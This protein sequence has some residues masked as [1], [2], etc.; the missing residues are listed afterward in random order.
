MT[1]KVID[2]FAGIGGL[3]Q[4]FR[5]EGFS[6]VLAN[7]I[8]PDIAD[9]Y[10]KNH[11]DTIMINEDIQKLD[12]PN[13]FAKYNDIDVIIGGPPCQGFSQK[14]SRK[15]LDDPRNFLFRN[16]YESVKFIKPKYFVIENVPT[17]LTA[18]NGM[19]KNEIYKLFEEIG[20]KLNSDVLSA[21][22]FGVP[23]L[24]KRAILIGRKGQYSLD[25]PKPNSKKITSWEAIS[26]LAYLNSGEGEFI[27]DYKN[28]PLNEYQKTLRGN[29][30]KLYNHEVTKHSS[31]ALER[32]KLIPENGDKSDLPNEHRTKSIYSGTWGR[33][34]KDKPSV[35]I[36]TRFD[37]PSSGRFVHPFLH[38]AITV[39]EAARL[40]SFP[41]S[42]IF[43]GSKTVQMKQ[44]GN[45]VPPLLAQ[46]IA[47]V[48]KNDMEKENE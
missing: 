35:T 28:K 13:V 12:I 2:L 24:R 8:D 48:I 42:T 1:K 18:K 14:G 43:Y 17:I 45:A 4:G 37:T 5:N 23:Q 29:E 25:M 19:F 10:K 15:L 36:T 32:M 20:Y 6:I 30:N 26:D 33:I 3:S 11:K 22:D 27:S 38:R 7:E 40:Q 34:I 46:A 21:Y 41:D 39:R 47:K 31:L 9:S 16:F 44:V